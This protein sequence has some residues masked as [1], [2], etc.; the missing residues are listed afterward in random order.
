MP[1]SLSGSTSAAGTS[2]SSWPGTRGLEAFSS[3]FST[4]H[5]RVMASRSNGAL[6]ERPAQVGQFGVH[7][8]SLRDAYI[9]ERGY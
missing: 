2:L 9:Q 5:A 1:R 6:G 3:A 7:L 8:E 4:Y